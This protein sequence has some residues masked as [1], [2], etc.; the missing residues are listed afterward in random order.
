MSGRGA[1]D[2][3]YNGVW[4]AIT[5]LF[6]VTRGG[7][8]L[9]VGDGEALDT[10]HPAR[11][12]LGYLKFWFWLFF[13]P[14]EGL[15][16][17]GWAAIGVGN[18]AVGFLL[19]PLLVILLTGPIV[20]VYVA[21]HLRYDN[22]WYVMSSRSLRIRRGIWII[23]EMTF[24]FENIQNVKVKSGPLQRAFGIA[25][26]IVETAAA[27]ADA[28]GRKRPVSNQGLIEGI[29]DAKRIRDLVMSRVRRSRSSGL[30]DE[31]LRAAEAAPPR[32]SMWTPAHL[33][34][35]REIRDE[36]AAHHRP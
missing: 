33:D 22:M 3:V 9:P 7:P 2:W 10:F 13:V 35:L 20:V 34:L 23:T 24:T 32:G 30:G 15:L 31:P 28:H 16:L 19:V 12:Y 8:T 27:G 29:A 17:I 11:G 18:V 1:S 26:V 4:A 14:F 5:A 25:D 36:L 21:I 6:K